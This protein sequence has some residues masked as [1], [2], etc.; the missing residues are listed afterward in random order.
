MSPL[1]GNSFGS[2]FC[3]PDL[4]YGGYRSPFPSPPSSFLAAS[5]LLWL[6]GNGRAKKHA[7]AFQQ[8]KRGGSHTT[9]TN[10]N[11]T[12][13]DDVNITESRIST[14]NMLIKKR[15]SWTT[16]A[17]EK[18]M[19]HTLGESESEPKKGMQSVWQNFCT[20]ASNYPP[21]SPNTTLNPW[22]WEVVRPRSRM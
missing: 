6:W 14:K 12:E 3:C 7:T 5:G 1:F 9:T 15:K 19:D 17:A 16:T 10:E 4:F 22:K 13:R 18:E 20:D 11:R 8:V 21:P 2:A